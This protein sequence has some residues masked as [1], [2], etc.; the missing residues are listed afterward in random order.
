M[1]QAAGASRL[2]RAAGDYE[3]DGAMRHERTN[4]AFLDAY[5]WPACRR[6]RWTLAAG[7]ALLFRRRAVMR[8][9]GICETRNDAGT[10]IQRPQ[11]LHL[12]AA[13]GQRVKGE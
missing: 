6:R 2:T 7:L 12:A 4:E 11:L 1:N 3:D 5:P 10:R 13:R 8:D 9:R